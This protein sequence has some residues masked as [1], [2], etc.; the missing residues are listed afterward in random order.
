M[1]SNNVY[2]KTFFI[3]FLLI[4]LYLGFIYISVINPQSSFKYYDIIFSSLFIGSYFFIPD[5]LR[6]NKKSLPL[7]LFL[8]AV[9]LF[10]LTTKSEAGYV[11]KIVSIMAAYYLLIPA[12]LLIW[13]VA[14]Y[15]STKLQNKN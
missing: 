12:Q 2:K 9:L 1:L 13:C 5:S 15:K 11:I 14:L 4:L 10:I 8:C 6:N 7:V 3:L